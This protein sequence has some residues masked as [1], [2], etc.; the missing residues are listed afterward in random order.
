MKTTRMKSWMAVCAAV[1]T[2]AA[3]LPAA[4]DQPA[5]A[6]RP[7]K[8]Y[9]GLVV[10]VDPKENT[11]EAK[12]FLLGKKFN[13][14]SACNYTFL[15]KGAGSAAD[16][17]P[18]QKIVVRYEDV[19]GVLVA[20]RIEQ[21][22]MQ[23]E[24][25]VEAIDDGTRTLT[26]HRPVS[27]RKMQI[28]DDCKIVLRNE[29]PGTLA[30]IQPGNYVTVIYEKPATK[31]VARRIEQTSMEFTGALTAMDLGE[32][33]VKAKGMFDTKKFNLADNCTILVNGKLDGRLSDLKPDEKLVFSYDEIDGVNVA[34]RIAPVKA[35]ATNSV[36]KAS[37]AMGGD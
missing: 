16:L 25:K 12:G 33:T 13:L 20:D 17:H 4:A 27:D 24:G 35:A 28:A 19:G 9:T 30:D 34:N 15:D 5:P 14:G 18:G 31:P 32:R 21:L 22:A 7:E 8:I 26:L 11:L 10:S 3:V 6:V 29:K 23:F 2:A 1:L 36:V 37:A